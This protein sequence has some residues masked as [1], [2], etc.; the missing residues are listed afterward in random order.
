MDLSK[1]SMDEWARIPL[2]DYYINKNSS[3]LRPKCSANSC[4]GLEAKFYALAKKPRMKAS[5]VA[6]K[7]CTKTMLSATNSLWIP[8][9]IPVWMEEYAPLI[10]KL[11]HMFYCQ[12]WLFT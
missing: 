6:A 10:R 8:S 3:H 1:D 12:H 4:I 7:S 5:I 9:C 11:C 2:F